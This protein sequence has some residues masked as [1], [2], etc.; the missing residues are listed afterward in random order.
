MS[1][2]VDYTGKE[3][4]IRS[5]SGRAATAFDEIP[6]VDLAPFLQPDAT[7]EA[8]S[9]VVAEVRHACENVGFMYFRGHGLPQRVMDKAFEEAQ[10]YFEQPLES[11][12]EQH[13]QKSPVF[14]GFEP[15]RGNVQGDRKEVCYEPAADPLNPSNEPVEH[16]ATAGSGP[17]VWPS[18]DSAAAGLRTAVLQYYGQCLV[19]GRKLIR[20]FS[21]A[22]DLPE[23]TFDEAFKV[24]GVLGRILHYPPQ[25]VDSACVGVN[26][27]TDI[28]CFTLLLQGPD[29]ECLEV[30][31]TAGEWITA[32]PIPG[33]LVCNIGDML[34]RWSNDRFISTVH[35]VV[36][37]TGQRRY[38][39]PVFFG[40]N[41]STVVKTFP[42]CLAEGEVS[43]YEPIKAG[44]YVWRR[45]AR[46]R[47]G[48]KYDETVKL[49]EAVAI[50]A[51]A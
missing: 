49:E 4:V 29:L 34:G 15:E 44:E 43:K 47:L 19:L 31:N 11:K 48:V 50:K 3:R 38:S 6:I 22:L 27:H 7:E 10:R 39:I 8:R 21:L 37:R 41:Y 14:R 23:D 26:Q 12:M 25:D 5:E 45:L 30:L 13:Y 28:E 2:F 33:T 40:P 20:L 46:S 36:N 1:K 32:P 16:D 18:E 51:A 35:R 17:N 42:S 24:P 9:K